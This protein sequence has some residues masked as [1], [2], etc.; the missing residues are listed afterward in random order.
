MASPPVLRCPWLIHWQLTERNASRL[1][2][3]ATHLDVRNSSERRLWNVKILQTGY[4][5]PQNKPSGDWIRILPD[6]WKPHTD[7]CD[8]YGGSDLVLNGNTD[9]LADDGEGEED[10]ERVDE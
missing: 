1:L 7:R 10:H 6:V 2:F 4:H 3:T 9:C 8:G 5:R